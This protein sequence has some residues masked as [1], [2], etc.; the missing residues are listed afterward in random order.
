M[1]DI[2]VNGELVRRN[3]EFTAALPG[4]VLAPERR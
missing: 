3:G 4:R 1:S 2:I